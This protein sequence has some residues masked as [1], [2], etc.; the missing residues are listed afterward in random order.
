MTF[1]EIY[2]IVVAGIVI[3]VI[4]PILRK[5]LP[6]PK[7]GPAGVQAFLPRAFK[8]AKPY[9]ITLIFA[10]ITAPLI[11]AL[12]KLDSW[13]P[14]LLAGFAWEATIEKVKKG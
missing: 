5:A 2:L 7:G 6:K 11:M 9:I 8:A 13:A 12:F 10:L 14:A 1:W 3:S 4:Y